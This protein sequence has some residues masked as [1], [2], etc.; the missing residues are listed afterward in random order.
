MSDLMQEIEKEIQ[1]LKLKVSKEVVGIVTEIGDGVVKI[2]GLSDV[3][4]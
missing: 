3:Q 2:E 4:Y 1:S